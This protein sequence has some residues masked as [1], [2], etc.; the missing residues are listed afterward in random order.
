VPF[1]IGHHFAS[2]VVDFARARGIKPLDFPYAQARRIYRDALKDD[3]GGE[4]PM[5]ETE[6]RST[7]DPVAIVNG[8]A[9]VGG[10]QPAEMDRM[11][12]LANQQLT[13]QE[14]WIS[15]R[16]ATVDTALARLDADFDKLLKTGD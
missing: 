10:P 13:Q 5:S 16:H 4:L 1:R 15:A 8:R 7:L 9:T 12:K 6:F 3:G 11:L 14:A 2:E